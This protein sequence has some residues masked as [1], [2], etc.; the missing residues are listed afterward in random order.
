MAS[1]HTT[2]YQL[3]QWQADDQVKRT[4]FNEDNAKL[5]A[6][7]ADLEARVSLLDRAVPDLANYVSQLAVLDAL[8]RELYLSHLSMHYNA[9]QFPEDLILTGEVAIQNGVLVVSGPGTMS[10]PRLAL[11]RSN[12]TQARLWLRCGSN[13]TTVP[14]LNGNE[15]EYVSTLRTRTTD[16]T[17]CWE[18]SYIWNGGGSSSAKIQLALDRP[19]SGPISVYDFRLVVF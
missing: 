9:F 5:E 1:N 6:A 7:L 10:T 12:W 16:N 8:K 4:D 17:V 3:C 15:M 19:S 2:N 18:R 14:S 13:A 11:G